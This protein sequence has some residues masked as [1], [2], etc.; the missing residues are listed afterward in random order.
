MG[1]LAAGHGRLQGTIAAEAADRL[2]ELLKNRFPHLFHVTA[3]L[4][5]FCFLGMAPDFSTWHRTYGDLRHALKRANLLGGTDIHV[6]LFPLSHSLLPNFFDY[7]HMLA[8]AFDLDDKVSFRSELEKGE[9]V[10]L[11]VK[12]REVLKGLVRF[13]ELSDKALSGRVK[14]SRQAVSKMRREFHETGLLRTVRIPNVRALG[15]DLLP[16]LLRLRCR[17]LRSRAQLRAFRGAPDQPL[18]GPG[19]ARLVRRGTDGL[20]EPRERDGGPEELR[21]PPSHAE[22][23]AG[24]FEDGTMT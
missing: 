15:F 21:L 19:A 7:S 9:P 6:T 16:C 24:R 23:V 10:T 14:V 1:I 11:T 17:R 20:P 2:R 22:S 12:E 4:D 18:Q 3:S 8:V 13:P 5:H